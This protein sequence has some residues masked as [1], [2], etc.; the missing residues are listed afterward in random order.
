MRRRI[1][2]YIGD[3][4]SKADI[5]DDTFILFNW[6]N[7][8]VTDPAKIK[9]SWSR[10]ITLPGTPANDDIFGQIGRADRETAYGGTGTG[11]Y[12]DPAR[13]TPFLVL[14]ETGN[15]IEKGY[16]K[17][18]EIV[19]EGLTRHSYKVTLY[20]GLGGL[21]YNLSYG[22]GGDRL[23]LADLAYKVNGSEVSLDF[24]ISA[25]RVKSAWDWLRSN[26][27]PGGAPASVYDI[28]NFAPAYNGLPKGSFTPKKGIVYDPAAA[29]LTTAVT[30]GG[31]T[32][33]PKDGAVIVTF[34]GDKTEWEVKDLRSYLQRPAVRLAAII[35]ACCDPANNGG[36]TITVDPGAVDLY[37]TY[38]RQWVTLPL[39]TTLDLN[40][41][42]QQGTFPA[43]TVSGSGSTTYTIPS[44]GGTPT[45]YVVNLTPKISGVFFDTSY[46]DTT[47]DE[48]GG[49]YAHFVNWIEVVAYFKQAGQ[50]IGTQ[51]LR[52]SS[53]DV[54]N[55]IMPLGGGI[56]H[57][58]YFDAGGNWVGP[59]VQIAWY[60]DGGDRY[61]E[62]SIQ[63]SND[64]TV[65]GGTSS[66]DPGVVWDNQS[67]GASMPFSMTTDLAGTYGS[68]LSSSARSFVP[69]TK[70][71]LLGTSHTP[72]EYLT[73]WMKRNN[74]RLVL[75]D[76]TKTGTITS[77]GE[78]YDRDNVTDI[79]ERINRT[80]PVTIRPFAF[81]ARFYTWGE[82]YGGEYAAYY[83][84]VYG[85]AY[86]Q[87]RVNTGYEFDA[88]TKDVLADTVFT[89]GVSILESSKYY[90]EIADNGA[91]VPSAFLD[92]GATY[93]LYDTD[94]NTKQ[95]AVPYP[96]DAAIK[97]WLNASH[98][99]F[100]AFDK[101]Q[102]HNEGNA[103]YD[104]RNTIIVYR[105]MAG[106]GKGYRLTDDDIVQMRLNDN[107][108][109]WSLDGGTI[110]ASVPQ[111]TRYELSGS[112]AILVDMGVPDE[113]PVPS[114]ASSFLGVYANQW[115]NYISD[116][117][118]DDA[119]VVRCWVNL[120]GLGAV[121][122]DLLR[123]FYYFDGAVWSLTK[124]LNYSLTTF[125]DTECEF[126]K[127][128]DVENYY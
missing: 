47:T 60:D 1:S 61:D 35:E 37:G 112:L 3:T 72:A 24:T 21:L 69:V 84:N 74:L 121:G 52:L 118:D 58:G 89:G 115:A 49:N 79:A 113:V 44:T 107:T 77:L 39:L 53:S 97:T 91:V 4:P 13:R 26:H 12:F 45:Q 117:Y 17:L 81:D 66:P 106:A 109:C 38:G 127:V 59:P 102:F 96:S 111:F 10:Q 25:A 54:E 9:N 33:K 43:R 28:I 18:D 125:D 124:I 80:K 100:D 83:R 16:L 94:G 128:K 71:Q 110:L 32:Y 2:L 29:G 11:I 82:Q 123:R 15:P 95:M 116:I 57:I 65:E 108:P 19:R 63:I 14:D 126:I 27:S 41:A 56:T 92:S 70:A 46:L 36:Y 51:V 99:S 50:V 62:V 48:G 22:Q 78:Y 8:E 31:K 73:S 68:A 55:S 87:H 104:V 42:G 103:P 40:I 75:D 88:A 98:P 93:D 114:L 5:G 119:K 20:G 30:E 86:G 90:C 76:V 64:G 7:W 34:P 6:S 101:V 105:G 120:E 67:D 23:S 122:P 85:R